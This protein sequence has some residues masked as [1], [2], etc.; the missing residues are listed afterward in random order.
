MPIVMVV[1]VIGCGLISLNL[2]V[3]WQWLVAGMLLAQHTVT[4]LATIS[5][6]VIG[7]RLT[8]EH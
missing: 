7:L 1:G 4:A 2:L 8:N 6:H 3:S 5:L